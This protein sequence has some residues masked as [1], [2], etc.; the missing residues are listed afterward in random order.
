MDHNL[1]GS[2]VQGIFQ[3]RILEQVAMPFSRG[4]PRLRDRTQVSGVSCIGRQLV[5]HWA[6][7]ETQCGFLSEWVLN[8]LTTVLVRNRKKTHTYRKGHVEYHWY[9][10]G[11]DTEKAMW[12][13]T[14]T[15]M[16]VIQP[17]AKQCPESP[18]AR[19]GKG[20][21]S[22]WALRGSTSQSRFQTSGL[23]SCEINLDCSV[24]VDLLWQ[25]QEAHSKDRTLWRAL[26]RR[27]DDTSHRKLLLTLSTATVQHE[28]CSRAVSQHPIWLPRCHVTFLNTS[29][30]LS[31]SP[32]SPY[33]NPW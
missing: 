22:L 27:S 25:P 28:Y 29:V 23:Q 18:G 24:C 26:T 17:K 11:S 8:P 14:D 10:D 6:T 7:W 30:P 12:S 19:I 13:I 5:Y 33:S 31:A 2:Y 3:A 15:L 21:F 20:G 4:S 1:P 32:P 16:G 9:S